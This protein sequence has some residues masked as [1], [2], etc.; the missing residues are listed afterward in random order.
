MRSPISSTLFGTFFFVNYDCLDS[1]IESQGKIILVPSFNAIGMGVV[2]LLLGR[3]R[4]ATEYNNTNPLAFVILVSVQLYGTADPKVR[5]AT[6]AQARLAQMRCM[7]DH[8]VVRHAPSTQPTL[9]L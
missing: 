4:G 3:R 1:G 7:A 2:A 5:R 9:S 8:N 6:T